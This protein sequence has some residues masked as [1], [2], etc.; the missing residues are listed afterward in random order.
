MVEGTEP[1]RTAPVTTEG[2]AVYRYEKEYRWTRLDGID[3]YIGLCLKCRKVIEPVGG[4]RSRSGTH[5]TDFYEHE[6]P[7]RFVFLYSSNSGNREY[8][9]D[10]GLEFLDDI[11]KSVWIYRQEWPGDVKDAIAKYLEGVT[12]G[13]S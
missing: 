8:G 10:E 4:Y 12:G 13:G 7:L 3:Y 9:L 1:E 5:G 11:V 2:N 6:H